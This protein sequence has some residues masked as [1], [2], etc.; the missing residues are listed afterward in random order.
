M[1]PRPRRSWSSSKD[2]IVSKDLNGIVQTWNRA[3][4][5]DV[6]I[7]RGGDHWPADPT[8]HP[9][10]SA[11]EEDGAGD[12][13]RRRAVEHF[14]TVRRR[15]DGRFIEISLSVSPV[16]PDGTIIGASK[17]ARDVSVSGGLRA[18]AEEAGRAKDE[19]LAMLSHEL[20]TPL[21]AVLGYTRMLRDG[22][23]PRSAA[24]RSS[25]SSSATPRILSQL[26]SD[27]L[28]VSGDRHRQGAA[29]ADACDRRGAAAG[30]G[31][32][33]ASLRRRQGR[34]PAL[35]VPTNP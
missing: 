20:R 2:A 15:K 21:N 31:R 13:P 32:Q 7:H 11:D 16:R 12:D 30:G 17:I 23:S 35:T 33:R 27:V 18:A 3:A 28:D 22:R 4:R 9:A 19:F 5:A 34:G 24:T 10:G 14:E 6:R 26:V 8:D 25:R 29:D 1:I